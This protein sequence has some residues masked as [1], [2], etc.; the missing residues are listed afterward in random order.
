M[1]SY[2]G[3]GIRCELQMAVH[4]SA[5]FLVNPMSSHELEIMQIGRYLC[6][7]C[8][9]GLIFKVDKTKGL[10][11]YVDADFAGGWSCADADNADNVLSITGFVIC[12]ANCPLVWCSKLHMEIAFFNRG[13]RIYCNISCLA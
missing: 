5:R 11:V 12:Y 2:L 4:Q 9:R 1:L 8:E 10:E 7:N 6:D 3:N 13:G